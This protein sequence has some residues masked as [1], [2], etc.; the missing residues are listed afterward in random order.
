MNSIQYYVE[1][2]IEG[3]FSSINGINIYKTNR[4]GS[5]LFPY[6]TIE[7]EINEQM[8]GSYTGLYKLNATLNYSDTSVKITESQFDASY[9]DIFNI[10]YN[11][12]A[13]LAQKLQNYTTTIQFYTA[14]IV[15]Q[16][17]TIKSSHRA[18]QKSLK[19]NIIATYITEIEYIPCLDFSDFRNSMYIPAI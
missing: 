6:I 8:L 9:S 2:A 10:L 5:R 13:T 19:L 1:D 18:W 11:N 16:T 15:N 17:P 7:T 3:L 4:V 14:N 12:T